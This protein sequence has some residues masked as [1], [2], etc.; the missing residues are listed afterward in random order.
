MLFNTLVGVQNLADGA[1]PVARAGKQADTIVSELHGRFYEQNYRNNLF[2]SGMT[3]TAI[4]NATFTTATLGPTC[5]PILGLWNPQASN[6]NAVILQARLLG[7]QTA[8]T[9]TGGGAFVWAISLG[10]GVITTGS[11][12]FNRKSLSQNGSQCKG[13][14]GVALTGLTNNLAVME[15]S[16]LQVGPASNFSLVGTAAGFAPSSVAAI[17]NVDGSII[18]PPGGVLALL[19]T[20]TPAAL[21]AASSLLW[22]EVPV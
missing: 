3:T 12:P 6:V 11:T 14:A 16:G 10:N 18:V 1:Q 8:A 19:A 13:F 2:S 15:G 5:T 7:I 22:E 9:T 4:S 17:E 21:S 20:T